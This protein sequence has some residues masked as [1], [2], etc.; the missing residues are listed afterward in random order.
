MDS[1]ELQITSGEEAGRV[2]PLGD[3]TVTLG[4]IRGNT[5]VL[6]DAAV[7]RQHARVFF[8]DGR[9]HL[10]DLRSRHGSLVNGERISRRELR[11]GDEV[12]LGTTSLRYRRAVPEDAPASAAIERGGLTPEGED[13]FAEESLE[14][15]PG[16]ETPAR[17]PG[18]TPARPP[19]A[20]PP[21]QSAERSPTMPS[22]S[23]PLPASPRG[24][25]RLLREDLDQRSRGARLAALLFALAVAALLG[26]GAMKLFSLGTTGGSPDPGLEGPEDGGRP[27]RPYRR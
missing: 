8:R 22:W 11:D 17:V 25:L 13:P 14:A 21:P 20:V 7:S 18:S 6:A 4:R 15:A 5:F 23:R 27:E 9:H 1:A 10:V 26:F 19:A 16:T 24:P 2:L 12:Q 3:E